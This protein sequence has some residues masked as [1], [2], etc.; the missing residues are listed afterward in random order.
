MGDNRDLAGLVLTGIIGDG[1]Q[2]AG[3]NQEIYLEGMGNGIITKKRGIRLPGRDLPEKLTFATSPYLPGISGCGE[4]IAS[5]IRTCTPDG[6]EPEV[7]LL[8]SML[9]LDAAEFSR[10]DALL[11]LYGD[12]YELEREVIADA[13]T[14]TMLIDACG[15]EGEGSTAAAIC[16]RSSGD[17]SNA[18]AIATSHRTRLINELRKTLGAPGEGPTGV[19]EISDK[20]LASD[21]ADTISGCMDTRDNPII[22]LAR[23]NDGTC[24]LSIRVTPMHPDLAGSDLGTLVHTLAED[25]GGFGG[26]HTTRAGAMVAC[27]HVSRFIAGITQVYA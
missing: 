18:W 11:N 4:E 13:H 9:V 1:Q 19:Y 23:Q 8:L 24:H 3:K 17:L 15:K 21:V 5:L 7:D 27:E 20:R 6:E 12:I 16:L 22:V 2:L 10:P 25:C 26:G 14:M